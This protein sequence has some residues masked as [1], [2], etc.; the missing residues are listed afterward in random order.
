[1]AAEAPDS[2]GAAVDSARR[3]NSRTNFRRRLRFPGPVRNRPREPV[4]SWV[5]NPTEVR[6]ALETG[7]IRVR[8][9]ARRR[10]T[11]AVSREGESWLLA[12]PQRYDPVRNARSIGELIGR[13][14][15]R[16]ARAPRSDEALMSRA[17]ALNERYFDDG[18]E[19]VSVRWVG[20]QSTRFASA[21]SAE[22]SIRVSDRMREVPEWVLDA[23]LVH[24]L[25]HLRRPDHSAEFRALTA[26]YPHT[27]RAE[28]FLEGFSAGERSARGEQRPSGE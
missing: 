2:G 16:S 23:L 17:T 1:M 6:E 15:R 27:E 5:M 28:A 24:E 26:R 25:A 9:S 3:Q 13:V 10:K 14:Q 4:R 7:L 20:N 22:R 21:T 12:V 8:R 19:P 18:V 11:I